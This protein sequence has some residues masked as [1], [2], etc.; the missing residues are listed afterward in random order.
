MAN[1]V[2]NFGGRLA[3]HLEFVA[4]AMANSVCRDHLEQLI[5]DLR[6]STS[7]IAAKANEYCTDRTVLDSLN[8]AHSH[9]LSQIDV[10]LVRGKQLSDHIVPLPIDVEELCSEIME[11]AENIIEHIQETSLVLSYTQRLDNLT[12]RVVDD[13]RSKGD[14]E[15]DAEER[16]QLLMLAHDLADAVTR[17][18]DASTNAT[19]EPQ[20][21]Q[22]IAVL[23]HAISDLRVATKFST[24]MDDN[25]RIFRKLSVSAR[26]LSMSAKQVI[27]TSKMA[28]TYNRNPESNSQLISAAR[29]FI[30]TNALLLMAARVYLKDPHITLS[31]L[32]LI[33]TSR[34]SIGPATGLVM[35]ARAA[36]PSIEESLLQRRLSRDAESLYRAI[37]DLRAC[38]TVAESLGCAVAFNSALDVCERQ[39]EEVRLTKRRIEDDLIPISLSNNSEEI[40]MQI[41]A[42]AKVLAS[43]HSRMTDAL[44]H[45]DQSM[46]AM[47][48]VDI[49]TSIQLLNSSALS[50]CSFPNCRQLKLQFLARLEEYTLH[51]VRFFSMSRDAICHGDAKEETHESLQMM[52]QNLDEHL[53]KVLNVMPG[54]YEAVEVMQTI[55]NLMEALGSHHIEILANDRDRKD[56][57][58]KLE[59]AVIQY[60]Q[61]SNKLL[62]S[63]RGPTELL[64]ESMRDFGA[65]LQ[66]LTLAEI[67]VL[68]SVSNMEHRSRIYQQAKELFETSKKAMNTA[69]M[70]AANLHDAQIQSIFMEDVRVSMQAA[71][72]LLQVA[73][74][75]ANSMAECENA[76]SLLEQCLPKLEEFLDG[77]FGSEG[78]YWIALRTVYSLRDQAIQSLTSS[79]IHA[80][81]SL[82]EEM[83]Q[84]LHENFAKLIFLI[85]QES[86][87]PALMAVHFDP[88]SQT[89]IVNA[90]KNLVSKCVRYAR[91]CQS[92]CS[93]I[94]NPGVLQILG[95]ESRAASDSLNELVYV[96]RHHGPGFQAIEKAIEKL[97]LLTDQMESASVRMNLTDIRE[98]LVASDFMEYHQRVVDSTNA[99]SHSLGAIADV[100][101][102]ERDQ[103]DSRVHLFLEQLKEFESTLT[104]ALAKAPSRRFRESL[105]SQIISTLELSQR[106]LETVKAVDSD[107]T[108]SQYDLE[109]ET[110]MKSFNEATEQIIRLTA[111]EDEF[112]SIIQSIATCTESLLLQE[113]SNHETS[114]T[115]SFHIETI[116]SSAAKLAAC[117]SEALSH[118]LRSLSDVYLMS[119]KLC[120]SYVSLIVTIRGAM[121]VLDS[122]EKRHSLVRGAQMVGH[123]VTKL[124]ESL[125]LIYHFPDDSIIRQNISV[126]GRD[127]A[128]KISV[129]IQTLRE[130]SCGL[131]A[132]EKVS[133]DIDLIVSELYTICVL[134][135]MGQFKTTEQDEPR[136]LNGVDSIS[137]E[138]DLLDQLAVKLSDPSS[139]TQDRLAEI[140]NSIFGE[141]VQLKE[142]AKSVAGL[143]HESNSFAQEKI[144]SSAKTISIQFKNLIGSV[145]SCY[146]RSTFGTDLKEHQTVATLAREALTDYSKLI[147]RLGDRRAKLWYAIQ[148][149]MRSISAATSINR[150]DEES[151]DKIAADPSAAILASK[152]VSVN[153]ANLV[154]SSSGT[155]E[156]I[157][158][159]LAVFSKLVSQ[160]GEVCRSCVWNTP[161]QQQDIMA[162]A[163]Y[164][165]GSSSI[166]LLGKI[167][168]VHETTTITD[169]SSTGKLLI[170]ETAGAV[171]D[172]C[173]RVADVAS[174]LIPE[175][176]AINASSMFADRELLQAAGSIEIALN[177]LVKVKQGLDEEKF[178][179]GLL[180]AV[181][182]MGAAVSALI[183]SATSAQQEISESEPL[184]SS[185]LRKAYFSDGTWSE[186]LVS[187]A[188]AV[189]SATSDLCEVAN[190]AI[191]G[192]TIYERVVAAAKLVSSA[193][194]HLL[195]AATVKLDV[196]SPSRE[197][198]AEAARRIREGSDQLVKH[199][200][201]A[202]ASANP[203]EG[204]E[205]LSL[206][207]ISAHGLKKLEME[208]HTEVL[209][210]EK[211]LGLA[212][213][214]LSRVRRTRYQQ[215]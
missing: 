110:A 69:K 64:Q 119:Q 16:H 132:C 45:M 29:N 207:Q 63:S 145:V 38:V 117:V 88:E 14:R 81:N 184:K 170:I 48:V 41:Y 139:F 198:L 62:N 126:T 89:R 127:V 130:G 209:R 147:G 165:V 3:T 194:V 32:N 128:S 135:S 28:S 20:D 173:G 123:A 158:D 90:S 24:V 186:G 205:N 101:A 21:E 52:A 107:Y 87:G 43:S 144:L 44:R 118:V 33:V 95:V 206:N 84:T 60:S 99:L 54:Q 30:E 180:G 12:S 46:V 146:G 42:T 108:S 59:F 183:I 25:A 211:D 65:A 192:Q 156:E 85:I 80:K 7:S 1:D 2:A 204:I 112:S 74:T 195:T 181:H 56:A 131:Y 94:Q 213:E 15:A 153:S 114:T 47:T 100:G 190:Q 75:S 109:L 187:A 140:V 50:F 86:C 98:L 49:I 202:A 96:L 115:S 120:A 197:M 53:S 34:A 169:G 18:I 93:N 122:E 200:S 160:L 17:V 178:E 82:I 11:A 143:L 133:A 67:V 125:R 35:A 157:I 136:S 214:E 150:F 36:F 185:D 149:N 105:F 111:L 58:K 26:T 129:L 92:Y 154:A 152:Q 78:I 163:I 177:R 121:A 51:L 141:L 9:L 171:A 23:R 189:A 8:I 104:E 212:R 161:R 199:A 31:Q 134:A 106:V 176:F 182:A 179:A 166:S 70:V 191:L 102:S 37:T 13:L 61:T 116:H 5:G 19:R 83:A 97:R 6:A 55:E 172:A 27:H 72:L 203:S 188:K 210:L 91:S 79:I 73:S 201:T 168:D 162:K 167:Q 164:Q 4:P 151:T 57:H 40:Q 137:A 208:A 174:H 155:D 71:I 138:T 142:G 148:D 124:V 196:L 103:L 113:C 193:T 66:D 76:I 10:F 175:G 39:L 159:A 68:Q 77:K 215:A 22:L